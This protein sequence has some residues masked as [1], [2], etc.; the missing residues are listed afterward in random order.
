MAGDPHAEAAAPLEMDRRPPGSSPPPPG[1]GCRSRRARSK[2][3]GPRRSR[4]PGTATAAPRSPTS[5]DPD[6]SSLTAGTVESPFRREAHGGFGE[7]S[8]ETGRE[9]SRTPRSG[10]TQRGPAAVTLRPS[11]RFRPCS[12]ARPRCLA[13]SH[14][15]AAATA[16][17]GGPRRCRGV[18]ATSG[19]YRPALGNSWEDGEMP[20]ADPVLDLMDRFTASLNAHDLDAVVALVTDDVVFESHLP[21]ARRRA[22]PGPGRGAPGLGATA[23]ADAAGPVRCRGAVLRRLGARRRCAG[24]TTGETGH[25]RGVD[26][27]RVRM[28]GSP[29]AWPMSRDSATPAGPGRTAGRCWPAAGGPPR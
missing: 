10:P 22:P 9:Q 28:A 19:A 24:A 11:A 13:G 21:A 4:S 6:S 5:L 29:R 25:V 20:S 14:P 17:P 8:G 27:I 23:R 26:I 2:C 3:G 18:A 12:A 16:A 15:G 7:R 1:G